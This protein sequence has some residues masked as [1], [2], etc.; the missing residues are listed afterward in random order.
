MLMVCEGCHIFTLVWG[1][2]VRPQAL[3]FLVLLSLDRQVIPRDLE[4]QTSGSVH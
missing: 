1:R 4:G 2:C 3:Y